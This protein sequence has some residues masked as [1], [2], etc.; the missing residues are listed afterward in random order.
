VKDRS[1]QQ[2]QAGAFNR[3]AAGLRLWLHNKK[4]GPDEKRRAEMLARVEALPG[5]PALLKTAEDLGIPIR[6]L[7]K[8]E[9][10]ADGSL[11]RDG[12]FTVSVANNGNPAAMALTLWHELRHVLQNAGNPGIGMPLGGDLKNARTSHMLALMQE[13]DAFTAETLVAVRQRRAGNPEYYNLL[14]A[15]KGEGPFAFIAGFLKSRPPENFRDDASFARALF[16][17]LMC[18]GLLAYRAQFFARYLHQF[19]KAETL[20]GFRSHLDAVTAGGTQTGPELQALYG[21]GFMGAT[22]ARAL[23]TAFWQ[24]QPEDER[25]AIE[26]IGRTVR[27]AHRLTEAEFRAARDE[28]IARTQELY[29]KDPDEARFKSPDVLKAEKRLKQ[30]AA[31]DKPLPLKY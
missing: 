3:A 19:R 7:P 27:R 23:A 22:S 13:A 16:T 11:S 21:A 30:S 5:G 8:K 25:Q 10:G 4:Y 26:M 2:K 9:I 29:F 1:G 6:V 31:A 12:G 18:D 28:I 24:A 15:G 20:D 17:D 14:L